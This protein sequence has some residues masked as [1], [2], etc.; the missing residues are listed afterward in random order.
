MRAFE[1]HSSGKNGEAAQ[2]L[3]EALGKDANHAPSLHLMGL[4]QHGAGRS[5]AAIALVRRAVEVDPR[6]GQFLSN[7]T[8]ILRADGKLDEAI[9]IGRM[10]IRAEPELAN[11]HC[12]LG[13]CY[14]D[15]KDLEQAEK[16]QRRALSLNNQQPQALNNL[17][18]I[19]RERKDLEGAKEMYVAACKA[20]PRYLECRNNLGAIL[21]ELDEPDEALQV[22]MPIVKNVPRYVEA[23]LNIGRAFVAKDDLEKAEF[24]YRKALGV[25]PKS[26]EGHLGLS[27]LL[28]ERN[29]SLKAF[30]E[31]EIGMDLDPSVP[32]VHHQIGLCL[33]DLGEVE[34]AFTSYDDA[35]EIDPEY[36]PALI[37][38]GHLRIEMGRMEEGRAD[39]VRALEVDPDSAGAHA[40]LTRID[41][42]TPDHPS[43]QFLE[44]Q[45]A[46]EKLSSAKAITVNF[47]LG[48][49]YEDLK[50]H[51][52]AFERYDAGCKL[53]RAVVTYDKTSQRN[54]VEDTINF[55]TNEQLDRLKAAEMDTDTPILIVGMP[56]SGTTLAESII[57]SHP[58]VFGG[59]ELPAMHQL[60]AGSSEQREAA[61]PN[62]LAGVSPQDLQQRMQAYLDVLE[63]LSKGAK[64]VTDKM[65]ANFS[66]IGLVHAVMPNAKIVHTIR[67]PLDTCLSCYT[68]LFDRSQFQSYDLVE[69]GEF[70]VGY[71]KLMDHWRDLLPEGAF[72]DL[73][74]E[75]LV[76]SPESGARKL[77]EFCSLDWHDN[78][79][80]FHEEKRRVRTASVTQ[81][82]QPIYK[83]SKAKW[84]NY[85]RQLQPLIDVI[86]E[87]GYLDTDAL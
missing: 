29:E 17:G 15:K 35:L 7:F 86:G 14:F 53:K 57:A 46:E 1:L 82:R 58:D 4:L 52:E 77:I 79:M 61:Y 42:V 38:R 44:R 19:L 39:I 45:A 3:Q 40:A 76:D 6:N 22:L 27:R 68:R 28:R 75:D 66:F 21:V 26:A 69:L 54:K 37:A 83:S 33:S 65:P 31:A 71:R 30:R 32:G 78:I 41:K 2:L 23:H 60:F 13:L 64:R 12:N 5:E 11:A 49:C 36:Q 8:E 16:C 20:D 72:Y 51:E 47:S 62:Q 43:F 73:V 10:A 59:G 18:S 80:N 87:A 48:K 70:Y 84:R 34:R 67:N 85:E 50:R 56:R 25:D 55:F 9:K 63:R 24:A 74:Y 81:V